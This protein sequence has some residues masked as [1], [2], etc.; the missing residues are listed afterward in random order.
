MKTVYIC[1]GCG[2]KYN[3]PDEARACEARDPGKR[4]AEVGD[5]VTARAGF[6]WF[7]G[8]ERWVIQPTAGLSAYREGR[9]PLKDTNCF[10]P[11][12]TYSFYYV[13]TAIDVAMHRLR[14]H[15]VTRA[16]KGGHRRGYT[17]NVHHCTPKRVES[18]SD[19][20]VRSGRLLIGEKAWGL[21]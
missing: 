5:I 9:C 20:L 17:F 14:Y 18:P 8:D 7:D 21:L 6:G 1:E 3:N 19:Y 2:E 13:V 10:S 16:M 4:L 15:L 12:C 11:C